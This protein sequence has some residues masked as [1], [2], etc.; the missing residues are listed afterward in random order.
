VAGWSV[1]RRAAELVVAP[2]LNFNPDA[3]AVAVNAGA[4]GILF[5]GGNPPPSDLAG[6]L[7]A[8]LGRAA[9]GLAPLVMADEEGGGIQRLAGAVAS[10]P[11]ARDLAA[12]R[13]PAQVEA[14]AAGVGQQMRQVGVNVDLAPVLDIDGGAGP[15][16]VDADG[17]RSFSPDPAVAGRYGLAFL[18][19]LR[20]AGVL[21]VVKHFPGLGSTV[22]NTDYGPART[23]PIATL[24]AGGLKP[25]QAAI[26]A[27]APA[28]M[29]ANA[30]V[31]GLTNL[32]ASLSSN[33]IN[34]L[35]RQ[36]LGF[37]GLVLTDSLS[38]GAITAAGYDLPRAAATSIG[39][40]ADLIL[41]GS[42]LTPAETRLLSPPNV[43]T[44]IRQIVAAIV[45]AAASG[46]LPM[47]RIDDAVLHVLAAKGVDLCAR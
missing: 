24:R 20:A 37:H 33:A 23:L 10:F 39:A 5:L 13:T 25:F 32:P 44:T 6:Q 18:Q 34:G 42:T 15:N 36:T 30:S 19:G 22:G 45:G 1:A 8:G 43:D 38:A 26:A 28:V 17:S 9:P 27:G 35:L 47:S 46:T 21:P 4:G 31:P 12:T 2:V 3:V 41:F 14:M 16:A 7:Q 40:G 11:W 29:V